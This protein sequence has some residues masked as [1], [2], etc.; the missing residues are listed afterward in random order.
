MNLAAR[1]R[2]AQH[3][4]RS[5]LGETWEGWG[6]GFVQKTKIEKIKMLGKDFKAI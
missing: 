3:F 1:V 2:V 6:K 4:I 5:T